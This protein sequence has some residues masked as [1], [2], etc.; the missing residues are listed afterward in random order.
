[1]QCIIC[2]IIGS[3]SISERKWYCIALKEYVMSI[4]Y[5]NRKFFAYNIGKCNFHSNGF[6]TLRRFN[7]TNELVV[8]PL[9]DIYEIDRIQ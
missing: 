2:Y 8:M 6:N 5:Y 4:R 3:C 1:M 7:S 9:R